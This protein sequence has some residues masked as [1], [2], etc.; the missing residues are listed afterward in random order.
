MF[1][2]SYHLRLLSISVRAFRIGIVYYCAIFE[3]F[4]I[5][6]LNLALMI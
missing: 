5:V 4:L 6:A 3:V 1:L 2:S